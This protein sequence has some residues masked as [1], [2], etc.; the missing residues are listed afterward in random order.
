MPP[1]LPDCLAEH[2]LAAELEVPDDFDVTDDTHLDALA[3]QLLRRFR[4]DGQ[5]QAFELLVALCRPRLLGIARRLTRTPPV[6]AED[7]LAR[8][9]ARLFTELRPDEPH[10]PHF[11]GLAVTTMRYDLLNLQRQAA[12]RR[13]RGRR[14]QQAQWRLDEPADPS[15]V[16]CRRERSQRLQRAASALLSVVLVAFRDLPER[17]RDVL[18]RRELEHLTYDDLAVSTGV[19]RTQIGMVL[20]RARRKLVA[21]IQST[22]GDVPRPGGAALPAAP[23]GASQEA[24]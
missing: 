5:A 19:P 12:R 14:W 16:A 17:D 11:L 3:A 22:L 18:V 2:P 15:D 7:L 23:V 4:A 9:L 21:R 1:R 13:R 6:E 8:F 20:Q 10:V 24:S